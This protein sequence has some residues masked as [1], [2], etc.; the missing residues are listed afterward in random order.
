MS[1]E[2]SVDIRSSNSNSSFR[3]HVLRHIQ[4][5]ELPGIS[6]NMLHHNNYSNISTINSNKSRIFKSKESNIRELTCKS[7]LL[8]KLSLKSKDQYA[9]LSYLDQDSYIINYITE[10]F[11]LKLK[12]LKFKGHLLNYLPFNESMR[13]S[14]KCSLS[15]SR[16]NDFKLSMKPPSNKI[17][18]S[19]IKDTINDPFDY[20]IDK[21]FGTLYQ[22]TTPLTFFTKST[23]SRLKSLCSNASID[24]ELI[25][26]QFI[27]NFDLFDSRHLLSNN[28]LLNSDCV[29]EKES[30]YREKFISKSFNFLDMDVH[31]ANFIQT[32]KSLSSVLNIFKIR[33]IQLQLIVLFELISTTDFD[34]LSK[35][36]KKTTKAKKPL[37]GKRKLMPVINGG[38][39]VPD[40]NHK[41]ELNYIQ[42]FDGFVD[43]LVIWETLNNSSSTFSSSTL[44]SNSTTSTTTSTTDYS[45]KKFITNV[46]IP[47]FDKK[48]PNSVKHLIKKIKGPSF[49]SNL[50]EERKK[51]AAL[52]RSS[53]ELS[54]NNHVESVKKISK[55]EDLVDIKLSRSNSDL[56]Q[57]KRNSSFNANTLS[58]R[59]VDISIP[60][61][62][63]S[64]QI[65]NKILRKPSTSNSVFNRVS[66]KSNS[67]IEPPSKPQPVKSFSQVDATPVKEQKYLNV[68]AT[69]DVNS[70]ILRQQINSDSTITSTIKSQRNELPFMNDII[71]SSVEKDPNSNLEP[72]LQSPL[73][74]RSK[75]KPGDPFNFDN[76]ELTYQDSKLSASNVKRKLFAPAK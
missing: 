2:V 29:F 1:L 15:A 76:D 49:R 36:K 64:S 45:S 28:G 39:I 74:I 56:Q 35:L 9:I 37:I 46:I 12:D 30:I 57:I 21:Y 44:S 68:L 31:S 18:E 50:K 72:I 13:D 65:S 5:S 55:L 4:V 70:S 14:W 62:A 17:T 75:P 11:A 67:F 34:D 32:N 20:F 27:I 22:L 40:L 53:S 26:K 59:Q 6:C 47:Y 16:L 3:V 42:Q 63:Q 61:S 71:M 48:C 19:P 33:E 58:R 38:A 69:P 23:F 54:S 60:S 24:Y 25:L 43:R 51:R 66:K 52:K 8:V 41:I 10:S 73:T 7:P